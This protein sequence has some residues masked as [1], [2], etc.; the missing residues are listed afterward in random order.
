MKGVIIVKYYFL[1]I[2]GGIEGEVHGPFFTE[3]DRD[4]A[5]RDFHNEIG[6]DFSDDDA[7]LWMDVDGE[8]HRQV[9]VGS[10]TGA[11]FEE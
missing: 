4:Q 2:L 9:E 8:A 7:I 5:A 10:Y 6:N 3:E 11:F 1:H